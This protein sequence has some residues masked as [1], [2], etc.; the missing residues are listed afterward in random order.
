MTST[1][2]SLEPLPNTKAVTEAMDQ[3]R[4]MSLTDVPQLPEHL[5][6]KY[7]L[8]IYA[9][10][11]GRV[12]LDPWYAVAGALNRPIDVIDDIG[13]FLFRA[14]PIQGTVITN[15]TRPI[16][17]SVG[18]IVQL[19]ELK[20]KISPKLGQAYLVNSLR[21]I[22]PKANMDLEPLRQLNII[23]KYYRDLN[24]EVIGGNIDEIKLP[25]A[26][27]L[28]AAVQERQVGFTGEYDEL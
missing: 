17:Q 20:S 18:E 12:N 21:A 13:V 5:F 27:E 3:I 23:F 11:T 22:A 7:I 1:D 25:S 26:I 2:Q 19:A 9:S 16:S 15:T 6:R 4:Q 24:L 8:P 14:P 28:E 10:T